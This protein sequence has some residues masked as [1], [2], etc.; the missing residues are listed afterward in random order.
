MVRR[1]SKPEL[2]RRRSRSIAHKI[3]VVPEGFNINPKMV[4]QLARRAKMGDGTSAH[5]LGLCRSDRVWLARARRHARA[6]EWSGF[7]TRHL[8]P[9]SC[10]VVRHAN[11]QVW[12]PLS[13]LRAADQSGGAF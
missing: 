6:P 11:R 1:L 13:E 4:G 5:R 2:T 7:R 8:Q 12:A 3:A 9:A 10:R